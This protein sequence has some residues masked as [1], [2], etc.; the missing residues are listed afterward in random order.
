VVEVPRATRGCAQ[1]GERSGGRRGAAK[2]VLRW[3]ERTPR[4]AS[5]AMRA[6]VQSRRGWGKG[7]GGDRTEGQ[8]KKARAREPSLGR[9][10]QS[11]NACLFSV[12]REKAGPAVGV[13]ER[14]LV[15][16]V[17]VGGFDLDGLISHQRPSSTPKPI[18]AAT[19]E[20]TGE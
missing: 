9:G 19:S 10:V 13:A 17:D 20:Y 11:S 12:A 16:K 4:D 8:K 1:D 18:R 2:G 7:K 15:G 3:S 14:R 6:A 5:H